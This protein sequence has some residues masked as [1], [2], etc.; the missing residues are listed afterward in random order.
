MRKGLSAIVSFSGIDGAG[1]STQIQALETWLT[2]SG[3]NVS[4]FSMWNDIVVS[5]RSREFASRCA[6][7]GDQGIGSPEEPLHRRDKNI[8]AWPLDLIRLCLY[9][10]DALSLVH[11]VRKL[12][13][14]QRFDVV[15]FDR[16]IYDELAN[17]PLQR[18]FQR[19]FARL[20][21]KLVPRPDLACL[22][23]AVPEDARRRKPEYPLDFLHRNRAAYFALQELAKNLLVIENTS[24][25]KTATGIRAA[26]L[27]VLAHQ[28]PSLSATPVAILR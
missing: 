12:Q 27:P 2:Q 3:L 24:I 15:I 19:A 8:T 1:K 10:A 26:L 13:R 17:L 21:L 18:K 28:H 16:Y 22:I 11:F 7:R 23:D 5:A 9:F 4:I 20:I 25:E 14:A 6:F